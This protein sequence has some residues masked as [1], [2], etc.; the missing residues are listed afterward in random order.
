MQN[1]YQFR[2]Q[3]LLVMISNKISVSEE[4]HNPVFYEIERFRRLRIK[5]VETLRGYRKD[6]HLIFTGETWLCGRM[7][8]V[9]D[10]I[11]YDLYDDPSA[12]R[13]GLRAAP[14]LPTARG[15]RPIV[16]HCMGEHRLV[17]RNKF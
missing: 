8:Q 1:I 5:F 10:W 12:R 13:K 9:K 16:L 17:A 11:N 2:L 7:T 3:E 14:A 6:G 15:K 4:S